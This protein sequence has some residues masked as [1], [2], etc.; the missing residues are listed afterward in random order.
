MGDEAEGA[1]GNEILADAAAE[2]S[3]E[4]ERGRGSAF[5]KFRS[6]RRCGLFLGGWGFPSFPYVGPSAVAVSSEHSLA[7]S[8]GTQMH[9]RA[10]DSK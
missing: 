8:K 3:A 9:S 4:G 5:Y 1:T 7:T 2:E 10:E 6:R